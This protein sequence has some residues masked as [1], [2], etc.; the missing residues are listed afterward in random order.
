MQQ[1]FKAIVIANAVVLSLATGNVYSSQQVPALAA[2]LSGVWNEGIRTGL[3]CENREYHHTFTLSA[4]GFILTKRYLVPYEGNF[5]RISE[6]RFRVLYGDETSL[7][8]FREGETFENRD[9]GDKV[10]RQLIL[11]SEQTY[12][13]RVYGMPREHRAAA[14]GLRCLN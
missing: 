4:D 5:G 11:E 14:G 13:W 10:I 7:T 8:L 1:M 3:T 6:E 12:A 2:K 9:T